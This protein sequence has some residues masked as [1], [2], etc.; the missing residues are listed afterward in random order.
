MPETLLRALSGDEMADAV[1]RLGGYAFRATPPLPPRDEWLE[2]LRQR[3]DITCYALLEDGVAVSEVV[4]TTMRQNLRGALYGAGGI[5]GVATAP[6]ARRRGYVRRVMQAILAALR[7]DKRPLAG[8]YPFRESFYERMGFVGFPAKRGAKFSPLAITELCKRDLGGVV[9]LHLIGD[10]YDDY[11]AYVT[12]LQ[13]HTHGMAVWEVG[14]RI[15]AQRNRSWVAMAQVAGETVG[16]M[17]YQIQGE[18]ETKRL[19]RAQ[20]FYYHTSAGRYLL[21]EWIAR[22]AGQASEAELHLSPRELPETWWPDLMIKTETLLPVPMERVVDVAGIGGMMVGP[23]AFTV[24]IVDSLCPWNEG[25]WRFTAVEGRLVV[26][27]GTR[28]EGTLSIQGLTALALGNHDPAHFALR[29]WGDPSP[30]LQ[31][32]MRVMFP[33]LLPEMHEEY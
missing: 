23:G 12:R 21:L 17:I 22:H 25:V 31:E 4:S 11:R 9:T 26:E 14:D 7:E 18:E 28:A 27:P 24:Q 15:G 3:Q 2:A 16:V 19:L 10:A 8:L 29:G 5:W 32:T 30:P 6:Q 13:Q 1:N 20:R 33:P